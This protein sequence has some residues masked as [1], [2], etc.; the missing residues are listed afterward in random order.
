MLHRDYLLEV[1]A[2]FVDTVIQS[3]TIAREKADPKAAQDV[4][5]AVAGLLDLDQQVAMQLT[6][7]SLVTMLLLSGVG[8]ALA[9]Y[10]TY[11]MRELAD[12]YDGMGEHDLASLRRKQ[13]HAVADSFG[14]DYDV[15]PEEFA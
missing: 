13:A 2:Q 1:I 3:L 8:D 7:D 9:D 14:C 15:V 10:V 11:A 4:E 5:A 12:V 6:P